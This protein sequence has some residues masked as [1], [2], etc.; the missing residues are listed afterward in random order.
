MAD[1][2]APGDSGSTPRP[3]WPS[4]ASI[5]AKSWSELSRDEFFDLVRLRAEVFIRGQRIVDE[6]EIDDTDRAPDTVHFWIPTPPGA[7]ASDF[8]AAAYL[9]L[10][11]AQPADR[12]QFPEATRSFGRVAV[13][14][15]HRG[16]GL[17]QQLV[18]RVLA[19]HEDQTMIIHAQEYVAPLYEKFGFRRVGERYQEAGIDHVKML[20]LAGD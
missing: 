9:R 8:G 5:L 15:A 20:R 10:T 14:P 17:A 2:P 18:A 11:A 12:E 16:S 3:A 4:A 13:H 6:A 7:P 19:D 1:A